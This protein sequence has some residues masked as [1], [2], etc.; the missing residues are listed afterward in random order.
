MFPEPKHFG[1]DDERPSGRP[2]TVPE[3]ARNVPEGGRRATERA[4]AI[5]RGDAPQ[6][7]REGGERRAGQGPEREAALARRRERVERGP[8][9][10]AEAVGDGSADGRRN[11]GGVH[12]LPVSC[13]GQK[14]LGARAR[15]GSVVSE[16]EA[17]LGDGFYLVCD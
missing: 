9:G 4:S 10:Q 11:V 13:I 7:G 1:P 5:E 15:K 2:L 16:L 17:R 3:R 12:V 14:S 8:A 6:A